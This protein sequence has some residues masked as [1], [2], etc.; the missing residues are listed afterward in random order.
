MKAPSLITGFAALSLILISCSKT[1]TCH[2]VY[3]T[4][5]SVS[6]Q[7][8]SKIEGKKDESEKKCADMNSTTTVPV[9]DSTYVNTIECE[10]KNK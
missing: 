5:G 8:D 9:G 2:C 1:Y 7:E 4:D 6:Y 10:L 3:K